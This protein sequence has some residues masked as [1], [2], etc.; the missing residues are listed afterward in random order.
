MLRLLG[1]AALVKARAKPSMRKPH[2]AP[3]RP[4]TTAPSR[5]AQHR[6]LRCERRLA[7]RRKQRK[8]RNRTCA[9]GARPRVTTRRGKLSSTRLQ[10]SQLE[11]EA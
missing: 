4:G 8:P 1:D 11:Q 2:G 3:L 10:A 7:A 5:E 9:G 6:F